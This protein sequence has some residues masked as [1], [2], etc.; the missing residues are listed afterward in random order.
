MKQI[1]F[2]K[3][4]A[5]AL[6]VA[7]GLSLVTPT[8]SDA[9]F[10]TST[11]HKAKHAAKKA[12][13]KI[14][15]GAKKAGHDIEKGAKKAGHDIEKG[16]KKT[17]QAIKKGAEETG[18]GIET[19]AKYTAAEIEKG[20][21]A[22]AKEMGKLEGQLTQITGHCQTA[23]DKF[24][25][26]MTHARR[27]ILVGGLPQLAT[28][29]CGVATTAGFM[30]G[31]VPYANGIVKAVAEGAH[32]MKSLGNHIHRAFN[33]HQCSR[34]SKL[35]PNRRACALFVGLSNETEESVE[36][37]KDVAKKLRSESKKSHKF[38]ETPI[39]HFAGN[40]MYGF[41]VDR[42][43][44]AGVA[45]ES[46]KLLKFAQRLRTAMAIKRTGAESDWV[47]KIPSCKKARS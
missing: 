6:A 17:G 25:A 30:C 5:L 36:C 34:Y 18:R 2:A 40:V 31:I 42:L 19:G 21:K 1:T 27:P 24:G 29:K 46:K 32:D 47:N 15:H 7:A 45:D 41:L 37:I 3:R 8:Q 22:A 38:D 35:D 9:N 44:L 14:S 4:L 26:P 13:H 16:A 23:I 33:S 43:A 10:F 20:A 28:S 39:C 11:W 12:G